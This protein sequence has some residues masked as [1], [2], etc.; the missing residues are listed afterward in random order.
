MTLINTVLVFA[1]CRT[2][3]LQLF[4]NVDRPMYQPFVVRLNNVLHS[5]PSKS[6]ATYH[7]LEIVER[8]NSA[9]FVTTRRS[10]RFIWKQK[11]THQEVGLNL[12]YAAC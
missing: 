5:L 4:T 10:P 3:A 11:L 7:E 2:S 9:I 8:N 1:R 12:D 6:N